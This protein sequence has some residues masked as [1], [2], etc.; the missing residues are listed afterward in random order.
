MKPGES[1]ANPAVEPR[2]P[3]RRSKRIYELFGPCG[4][5][6]A[7]GRTPDQ[8]RG[9][10]LARFPALPHDLDIVQVVAEL[11]RPTGPYCV[12]HRHGGLAVAAVRYP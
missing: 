4:S 6:L 10:Y 1:P 12:L 9:V 7:Q 2:T 3:E 5:L 11:A 8:A